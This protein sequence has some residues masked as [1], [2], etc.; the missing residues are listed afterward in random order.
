MHYA[1]HSPCVVVLLPSQLFGGG[2]GANVH[3]VGNFFSVCVRI[4]WFLHFHI[5]SLIF[6]CLGKNRKSC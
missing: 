1:M 4:F 5:D 2:D 3:K 6:S